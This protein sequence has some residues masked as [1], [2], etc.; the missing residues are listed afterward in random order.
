MT[1]RTYHT[2]VYHCPTCNAKLDAATATE[3]ADEG[4]SIGDLLICFYCG[5]ILEIASTN[6]ITTDIT[7]LPVEQ[8]WNLLKLSETIRNK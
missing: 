5:E 4:P 7:K 1:A 8:A 6:L 3:E 2:D